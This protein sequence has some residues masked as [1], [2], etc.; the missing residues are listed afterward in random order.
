M[1]FHW[2]IEIESVDYVWADTEEE[3]RKK[4]YEGLCADSADVIQSI[5]KEPFREQP[6]QSRNRRHLLP[7]PTQRRNR[8]KPSRSSSKSSRNRKRTRTRNRNPERST[9]NTRHKIQTIIQ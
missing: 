3:A 9:K 1:S 5:K 8:Q 6:S 2:K 7:I 4:Y